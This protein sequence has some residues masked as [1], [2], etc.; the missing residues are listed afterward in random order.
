M[1]FLSLNLKGSIYNASENNNHIIFEPSV[2]LNYRLNSTSGLYAAI[3]FNKNS[4]TSNYL[5][6]N[7]ILI[8]NRTV[9]KNNS[10][11]N[12]FATENYELSYRLYDLF[13]QT[14]LN[15]GASYQKEKGGFFSDYLIS[16]NNTYINNFFLPENTDR[17]SFNF[18]YSKLISSL[19]TNVKLNSN[20]S[21]YNYKNIVNASEL[22]YNQSKT[23]LHKLLLKT[24]FDTKINFQNE[25]SY[26]QFKTYST[27][28]FNIKS[29]QNNFK[30][31]LKPLSDFY[32]TLSFDYFIPDLIQ[33]SQNYLFIDSKI[34]YKPKNKNWEI[35][36][37]GTNLAN[38][39]SFEIIQN[40]DFSTHISKISLLNRFVLL[41]FNYNF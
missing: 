34:S 19:A 7:A 10:N 14:Q 18:E 38:E 27:E 39:K 16:S 20:Y 3:N 40:T 13:N 22:R 23:I 37:S 31:I 41:H 21:I 4:N 9:L 2:N 32:T 12:L 1:R 26:N 17:L 33:A 36:I 35:G 30:I 29:I 5:F 25:I 11:L 6:T 28:T 8:N 24:A 15:I